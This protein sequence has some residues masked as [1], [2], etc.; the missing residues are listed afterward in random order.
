MRAFA[1]AVLCAL[2]LPIALAQEGLQLSPEPGT[3]ASNIAVTVQADV[4]GKVQY[5]FAD[6]PERYYDI[7]GPLRLSALRGEE[8][9]YNLLFRTATN[10]T[11]P[12]QLQYRIV[13]RPP[14]SPK[15]SPEERIAGEAVAVEFEAANSAVEYRVSYGAQAASASRYE[16]WDGEPVRLDAPSRGQRIVRIQARAVNQQGNRSTATEATYL[17]RTPYLNITSP[18]P[19]EFANRQ[20][21]V[22]NAA[23]WLDVRY[24][25]DGSNPLEAGT[26]Y[27]GPVMLPSG[28][29]EV[30]VAAETA[31]GRTLSD[32]ASF[33]AGESTF[34]DTSQGTYSGSVT[35]SIPD[36][37]NSDVQLALKHHAL[38]AEA[39]PPDD[40]SYRFASGESVVLRTL[41]GT[42]H[43]VALYL[44]LDGGRLHR[45][46]FLLDGREVRQPRIVRIGEGYTW[47]DLPAARTEVS[48]VSGANDVPTVS[49]DTLTTDALEAAGGAVTLST[50][51]WDGRESASVQ[52]EQPSGSAPAAPQVSLAPTQ[53]RAIRVETENDTQWAYRTV[54]AADASQSALLSGRGAL[55]RFE[56]PYGFEK[57]LPLEFVAI[58]SLGRRSEPVS[59]TADIDFRPPP[60]PTVRVENR[61]LSVDGEGTIYFRVLSPDSALQRELATSMGT[62]D[63]GQQERAES[64]ERRSETDETN[65][66]DA[67]IRYRRYDESIELPAPL[68]AYSQFTAEAYAVDEAGNRSRVAREKIAI[69]RRAALLP[70]IKGVEDGGRYA[71]PVTLWFL[72]DEHPPD[73][74]YEFTTDGSEPAEPAE[75]SPLI[76]NGVDFE[77]SEGESVLVRLKLQPVTLTRIGSTR[78]LSFTIDRQ[79]PVGPEV[80]GVRDGA[81]YRDTRRVTIRNS[82]GAPDLDSVVVTLSQEGVDR[83]FVYD[84]PFAVAAPERD[85][86]LVR[87]TAR[88]RDRAGNLSEPTTVEFTLDTRP[89]ETPSLCV[90][91]T[92]QSGAGDS[93]EDCLRTIP[94]GANSAEQ[95]ARVS[96]SLTVSPVGSGGEYYFK[97]IGGDVPTSGNQSAD[98]SD[99]NR[100][101]ESAL[102]AS[103]GMPESERWQRYRSALSLDAPNGTARSYSLYL[104][105]IDRAGNESD[106]AGPFE[107]VIDRESPPSPPAPDV[108]PADSTSSFALSWPRSAWAQ[109]KIEYRINSGEFVVYT[110]EPVRVAGG[111]VVS[112]RAVDEVGNRS[113]TREHPIGS[114]VLAPPRLTG[115]SDG[116]VYRNGV[117]ITARA[118][119]TGTVRY[120]V[121]VDGEAVPE[122][123]A[124]SPELANVPVFDAPDRAEVRYTVH[125]RVVRDSGL[126]SPI[127]ARSFTIDRL[128]PPPPSLTGVPDGAY[129]SRPTEL[130][131]AEQAASVWYSVEQTSQDGG[132]EVSIDSAD[133]SRFPGSF[134][135]EPEEG[136][137]VRYR[138]AAY[139]QDA[140]GNRS[141]VRQWEIFADAAVV[142]V[143]AGGSN[144][145]GDGSREA[146]FRSLRAAIEEAKRLGRGTIFV[147]SGEYRLT[148][149]LSLPPGLTVT[150]AF[151]LDSWTP[152][153]G[154]T[155]VHIALGSSSTTAMTVE[156]GPVR[157][158]RVQFSGDSTLFD[159]GESGE[160]TLERSS[161]ALSGGGTI[162]RQSGGTVTVRNSGIRSADRLLRSTGDGAFSMESTTV[163]TVAGLIQSEGEAEY[164]IA[165]SSIDATG[166]TQLGEAYIDL[167]GGSITISSTTMSSPRGDRSV[168]LSVRNGA[169]T[170]IHNSELRGNGEA[171]ISIVA[172]AVGSSLT[173]TGSTFILAGSTG[174]VG[175]RAEQSSVELQRNRFEMDTVSE[176]GYAISLRDGEGRIANN[177][178]ESGRSGGSIIAARLVGSDSTW[179]FNSVDIAG[180]PATA[181]NI[182]GASETRLVGNRVVS[183]SGGDALYRANQPGSIEIRANCLSGWN[184]TLAWPLPRG[185][186]PG[187]LGTLSTPEALNR[188]ISSPTAFTLTAVGNH[189]VDERG[190]CRPFSE[191][192]SGPLSLPGQDIDGTE[193]PGPDGRYTPGALE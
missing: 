129:I 144:E 91:A 17:L 86:K 44:Q 165:N 122:V 32:R 170:E 30:R 46:Q 25:V 176:F 152:A 67:E 90:R 77:G 164:E 142:Y 70:R 126:R 104:R 40:R 113:E 124:D 37:R 123:T 71:E 115:A 184:N 48:G 7:D 92:G 79:A 108:E 47:L 135:I 189:G 96:E 172:S 65:R 22:V 138:I 87:L 62:S 157:F 139:S 50:V 28:E 82:E 118:P 179:L 103:D 15:I 36:R 114:A 163:E 12:Q 80:D 29:V 180:Q 57:R 183:K 185:A 66:S 10:G 105:A 167:A 63:G 111:S 149:P 182:E 33:S 121:A 13:R 125:T 153:S 127:E 94:G 128:A 45:Y 131:F 1:A 98:S 73:V 160:L 100:S 145:G 81:A 171:G 150:G 175:I 137:L 19:G 190:N 174:F 3:Y 53:D 134:T 101:G 141:K 178:I 38:S 8:R 109:E 39:T 23:P 85:E 143:A 177:V 49:A 5:A 93:G 74:R 154:D 68:G 156:S 27:D 116:Q 136:R 188:G 132:Q 26:H 4:T 72:A 95:A 158:E 75:D 147:S 120:E 84:Q 20:L 168:L 117:S 55:L 110:G 155:T 51:Y 88:S 97:L 43:G 59:F 140:A 191:D 60:L 133:F 24:T 69:D 186:S 41:A 9:T 11:S 193:R 119:Q 31:N 130:Q 54:S 58:D 35:I 162:L 56:A 107:V 181:F 169:T 6:A 34:I 16:A 187:A 14:P 159:I 148:E 42:V 99:A 21:L 64:T 146:P 151:S 18:V 173:A 166:E 102:A 2:T 106:I 89:P 61:I 78:E 161:L 76:G 52:I 192:R 83:E 112:Y